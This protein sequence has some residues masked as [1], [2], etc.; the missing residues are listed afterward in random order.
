LRFDVEV[1]SRPHVVIDPLLGWTQYPAIAL[2]RNGAYK[3]IDPSQDQYHHLTEGLR[4]GSYAD[5]LVRF[6]SMKRRVNQM[7]G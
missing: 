1:E 2:R 5:R 3:R 7:K 6:R 4:P